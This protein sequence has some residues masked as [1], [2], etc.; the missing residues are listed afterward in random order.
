MANHHKSKNAPFITSR[1]CEIQDFSSMFNKDVSF[2]FSSGY[3]HQN[4]RKC[5]SARV[6]DFTHLRSQTIYQKTAKFLTK[7]IIFQ[8]EIIIK[9]NLQ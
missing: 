9:P 3:V 6:R 1:F 4:T 7:Q 5:T 8:R 2:S